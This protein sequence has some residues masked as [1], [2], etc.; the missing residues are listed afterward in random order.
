MDYSP[1]F[2]RF[3]VIFTPFKLFSIKLKG[4]KNMYFWAKSMDYI[5]HGFD[6]LWV[7]FTPFKLLSI[8]LRGAKNMQ[9]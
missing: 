9:F 5:A 8:N 2:H 7:I 4:A 3:W 1:W 6:R